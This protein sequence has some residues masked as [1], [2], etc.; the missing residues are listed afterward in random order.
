MQVL[1]RYTV[2]VIS[3]FSSH[4]DVLDVRALNT[5]IFGGMLVSSYSFRRYIE[6]FVFLPVNKF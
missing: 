3:T 1:I 5:V 2:P 4:C 6:T